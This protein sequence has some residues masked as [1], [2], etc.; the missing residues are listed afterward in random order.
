MNNAFNNPTPLG[1][2]MPDM[3]IDWEF[4][5]SLSHLLD[6]NDATV[7]D[8]PVWAETMPA[9]FDATAQSAPFHEALEGLSIRE[10]N[11]PDIFRAFFGKP[12]SPAD[13][14]AARP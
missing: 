11:E 1:K 14:P 6:R 4:L 2:R 7:H 12:E 3:S 8:A 9:E 5:P 13:R 10:V